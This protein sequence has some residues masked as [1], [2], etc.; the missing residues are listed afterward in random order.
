MPLVTINRDRKAFNDVQSRKLRD[1]LCEIVAGILCVDPRT[2]EV[3]VRNIGP[4]DIN[5]A[6]VGIE[7]DTGM[8]AKSWR[9]H[10]RK[11]IA[12]GIANHV[13]KEKLIPERLLGPSKSYAWLRVVGSAFV[14]IGHPDHAR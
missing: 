10:N 14:P 6:P 1:A 2:V 11:K 4:M 13:A 12:L 8:G 3:R 5:F 7:I 9:M